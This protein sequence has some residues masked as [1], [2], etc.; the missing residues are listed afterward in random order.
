M[1][2][3][4]CTQAEAKARRMKAAEVTLTDYYENLLRLE[5]AMEALK[6]IGYQP[7]AARRMLS[8]VTALK[9]PKT[10]WL[11]NL[12]RRANGSG[13]PIRSAR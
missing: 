3:L 4:H 13:R 8:R 11:R 10:G 6:S 9:A 7:R 5:Y 1:P 2:A 12:R